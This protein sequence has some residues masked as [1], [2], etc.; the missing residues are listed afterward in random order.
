MQ[1]NSAVQRI[2]PCLA[3]GSFSIPARAV[4]RNTLPDN[5]LPAY[6]QNGFPSF[7]CSERLGRTLHQVEGAR[8]TGNALYGPHIDG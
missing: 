2:P 5:G 8:A 7:V 1:T 6:S 4:L 3:T